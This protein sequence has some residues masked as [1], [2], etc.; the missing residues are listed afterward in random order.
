M[1]K[2]STKNMAIVALACTFFLLFVP[3]Y[4]QYQ[5]SPIAHWIMPTYNLDSAQ[6]SML[7]SAAMIPGI[8]LSLVAGL[9]A[10]RFGVKRVVSI[11]AA[12]S[13]AALIARIF[14]PSFGALFI[15]MVLA[16]VVATFLNANTAKI[17]GSWFPPDKVGVAV[18]IALAGSTSSML[19]GLGTSALFPSLQVIFMFTAAL[20]VVALAAWLLFFKD[21]PQNAKTQDAGQQTDTALVAQPTLSECLKVVL[22]NRN[23]WFVGAALGFDL[24]A[25]MCILTFL[26]QALQAT[27][28]FDPAAAGALSSVVTLGN[29]IGSIVAPMIYTRIGHFKP[30]AVVFAIIA[31]AGTA[32]A[33]QMPDGPLM[34]ASLFLTGFT[35]SGLMTMFVSSIVLLPGIGPVYAGTAGGVCATMQLFGAVVIPSYILAPILGTN[36]SML[37]IIAGILCLLIVV[38]TFVLPEVAKRSE[39]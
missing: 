12:I 37:Y 21:G 9:L 14:A 13:V 34:M 20:G 10:D 38:C 18:G 2:K 6:F 24:A 26:P 25:T 8:L 11:A 36:Y 5:L 27:R 33:W 3:N 7:F 29:L 17:M 4:A 28:G 15:C 16:G 1:D 19:V 31:A 23:V 39:S 32:F 30:V 35:L 22:K